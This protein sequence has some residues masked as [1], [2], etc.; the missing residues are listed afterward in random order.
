MPKAV[1]I[2]LGTS[3]HSYVQATIAQKDS[4][5]CEANLLSNL[6]HLRASTEVKFVVASRADFDWAVTLCRERQELNNQE[7]L[8]S[9]AYGLV[10]PKDLV[11]WL[12]ESGLN[13]RFQLQTHKVIW[14]PEARGV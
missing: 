9:P 7:I 5:E 13:A 8:F 1:N 4:G 3:A 2:M 6:E 12:M 11:E 14:P 10:H